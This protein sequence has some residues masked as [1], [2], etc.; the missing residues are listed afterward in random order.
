MRTPQAEGFSDAIIDRFFR[1]FLG[2]IFFD[3]ELQVTSRLFEYVMRCLA[4]GEN[5][6]PAGGIGA[7]AQ[8]LAAQIPCDSIHTGAA[9]SAWSSC[10]SQWVN[11]MAWLA[12][13]Y[14]TL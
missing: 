3:R 7:V 2:G 6:L 13:Q 1:P 8:Q 11:G 12:V 10:T 9:F 14:T 4:T 5:C